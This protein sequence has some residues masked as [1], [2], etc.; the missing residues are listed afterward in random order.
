MD[1]NTFILF[2]EEG[3]KYNKESIESTINDIVANHDEKKLY[4]WVALAGGREKLMK[5][6]GNLQ[7][8]FNVTVPEEFYTILDKVSKDWRASPRNKMIKVYG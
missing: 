4:R 6:L 2:E 1:F 3:I 8:S 7:H 5:L